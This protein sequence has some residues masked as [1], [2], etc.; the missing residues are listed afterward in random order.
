MSADMILQGFAV[1]AAAVAAVA[2]VCTVAIARRTLGEAHAATHMASETVALGRRE[3]R[4]AQADR[5][6]RQVEAGLAGHQLL[7]ESASLFST[8]DTG[9]GSPPRTTSS[10]GPPS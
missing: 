2:A 10:T 8:L 9:A 7:Y 4:E 1:V 6:I 3:L 5:A